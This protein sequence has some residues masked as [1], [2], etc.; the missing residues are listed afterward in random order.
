MSNFRAEH[1]EQGQTSPVISQNGH[2]TYQICGEGWVGLVHIS[3]LG[4][5]ASY[6]T[7]D[8]ESSGPSLVANSVAVSLFFTVSGSAIFKLCRFA[9]CVLSEAL[10]GRV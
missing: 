1:S 3:P 5:T 4:L 7:F 8:Y 10:F 9:S 2:V 6:F